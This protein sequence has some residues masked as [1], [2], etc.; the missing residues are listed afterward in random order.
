MTG[1][2]CGVDRPSAVAWVAGVVVVGG[3][4]VG[5]VV[6]SAGAAEVVVSKPNI[7]G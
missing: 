2:G 6:V 4:G 1:V 7:V 5:V 3:V